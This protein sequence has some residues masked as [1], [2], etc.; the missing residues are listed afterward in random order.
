MTTAPQG[1]ARFPLLSWTTCAILLATFALGCAKSDIYPV[2]GHIVD[3][4]GNPITALKGGAVEFEAIEGN[5]SA[6]SSIDDEGGFR[7]TTKSPGDG[8]KVGKHRVSIQRRYIGPET[9]VPHVILPRYEKFESS[10][11]EVTVEPK[12][13]VIKL[14]VLLNKRR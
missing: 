1:R 7:L 10:G 3:A 8:A 13:N 12:D 2:R 11:L 6:N 14:E 4:E 9:P 5:S